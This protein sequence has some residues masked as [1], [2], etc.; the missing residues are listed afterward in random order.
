MPKEIQI[1]PEYAGQ[2]L[3]NYLFTQVKGVPKSLLYRLIR[4][5]KLRVNKK[6]VSVSYRLQADDV[7]KMPEL[8]VAPKQATAKPGSRLTQ[9]LTGRILYEDN[10]LLILNKPVGLAVHGGSG[11]SR[12]LIETL[13]LIR[14]DCHYLE[15]AHRLDRDTSGCLIIAK[16]RATLK[17][18]HELL[19]SGN[20]EKI[21]CALTLGH[22][23]KQHNRIDINL[24]KNV[25]QSGE[26]KVRVSDE[27]KAAITD[28]ESVKNYQAATLVKI[29]LHTGRMHQIRA[30]A[31]AVGHPVAGDEKYGDRAFNR[32]MK[33]KGLRRMFLHAEKITFRLPDAKQSISVK[34]PLDRELEEVLTHL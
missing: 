6:R 1:D 7:L 23:P 31:S 21:Y 22:W 9:E 19:R 12:G 20:I 33:Q 14:T 25:A 30:H 18:L 27:G 4:Q 3:D 16:N 29:K 11:L 26:R 8:N 5:G 13:R 24:Q 10:D 32:L 17:A 15:L 34:A 28:F 2:R